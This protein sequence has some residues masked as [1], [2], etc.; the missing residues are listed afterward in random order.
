M[1]EHIWPI[2]ATFSELLNLKKSSSPVAIEAIHEIMKKTEVVIL[3]EEEATLLNRS[4]NK[5][6][7]YS[8]AKCEKDLDCVK[9]G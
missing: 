9:Q 3:S 2:E 5:T 4:A 8:L 7:I 6:Y 1:Y